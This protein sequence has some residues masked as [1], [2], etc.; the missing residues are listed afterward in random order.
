MSRIAGELQKPGRDHR[1]K[2][3][4]VNFSRNKDIIIIDMK[5]A[6]AIPNLEKLERE[7]V[8]DRKADTVS[9][10]DNVEFSKP[11]TFGTAIVTYG[12][13]KIISH[14]E[15]LISDRNSTVKVQ[16]SAK[17]GKIKITPEVINENNG[18][19]NKP[20]RVGL[21]FTALVTQ[22]SITVKYKR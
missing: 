7:F 13:V 3:S 17:G 12:K 1:G 10:T 15:L 11:E 22:A 14:S 9:V 20:T 18:R 21:N 4:K 5:N 8:Y 2:I 6:Y 16:I 19:K